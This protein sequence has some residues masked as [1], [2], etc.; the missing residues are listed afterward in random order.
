MRET[1]KDGP[2]AVFRNDLGFS[3]IE[4]IVV[5]MIIGGILAVAIP[6]FNFKQT[7]TK[8]VIRDLTIAVR[9]IRNRAKLSSTSYRLVVQLSPKEGSAGEQK[10]WVEKSSKSTLIDK[11]QLAEE[12]EEGKN[13]FRKNEDEKPPPKAFNRDEVLGKK[14]RTLPDGYKFKLVESG[15][16]EFT[17]IEGLAYIHFFP[18]GFIEPSL[19]QI[20]DP[21]KNIWTLVFNPITGQADVIDEAKTLKDISTR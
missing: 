12:R 19:I 15:S 5:I 18:Q 9:E 8:S 14:D 10:Y 7:N 11:A 6:R 3:M 16:Q 17:Y 21:K 1:N 2:K 13:T 20:E 4:I